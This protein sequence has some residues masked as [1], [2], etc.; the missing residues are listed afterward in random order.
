MLCVRHGLMAGYHRRELKLSCIL[1][2]VCRISGVATRFQTLAKAGFIR[3]WCGVHQLDIVLQSAYTKTRKA[4][5]G[6]W[7]FRPKT[8]ADGTTQ[9]YK[10]RWV[11]KG[12]QQR[13]G[14]DYDDTYASVVRPKPSPCL[15]PV[16]PFPTRA[17]PRAPNPSPWH[18]PPMR[19][20]LLPRPQP[21]KVSQWLL[22]VRPFPAPARR[23]R[24]PPS[25]WLASPARPSLPLPSAP[26][27][28]QAS[29]ARRQFTSPPRLLLQALPAPEGSL[30]IEAFTASV[31]RPMR[32]PTRQQR[33]HAC[34]RG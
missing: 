20:L 27:L 8:T 21:R 11:E 32:V 30:W 18:A 3:I 22:P 6:R 25:T 19:F 1:K 29:E 17:R 9:R 24:Q 7:V 13:E 4:I 26:R 23:L 16:R 15:L 5:K 12:F 14:T 34:L 2:K 10:A 33:S 31:L 28:P